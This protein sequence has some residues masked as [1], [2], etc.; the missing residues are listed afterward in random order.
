MLVG[1]ARGILTLL[2]ATSISERWG[3]AHYGRLGGL[4]AAPAMFATALAPWAGA[5]LADVLGGYANVF[6]LLAVLAAVAA[7]PIAGSVPAPVQ[8]KAPTND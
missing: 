3:S 2:Q 8:E 1:A 6:L 5:A 7:I 4:L